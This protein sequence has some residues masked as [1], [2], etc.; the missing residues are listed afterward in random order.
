MKGKGEIA[1]I[2]FARMKTRLLADD[3]RVYAR[4]LEQRQVSP[5]RAVL[6]RS[7]GIMTA[8]SSSATE[9]DVRHNADN[10]LWRR[11]VFAP[12][13]HGVGFEFHATKMATSRSN[14]QHRS[15]FSNALI[16]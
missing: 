8:G 10:V 14:A 11:P 12:L 7:T 13:I 15:F 5:A 1:G 2:L 16:D 4:L 6:T 9:T 3:K